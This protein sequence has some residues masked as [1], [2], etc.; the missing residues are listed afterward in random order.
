YP[1]VKAG[2]ETFYNPSTYVKAVLGG[3]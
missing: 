2:A 1:M 3:K